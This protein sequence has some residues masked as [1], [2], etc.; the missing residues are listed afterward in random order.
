M[1]EIIIKQISKD[2]GGLR[3]LDKID[4]DVHQGEVFGLIGTNGSGKSTLFNIITGFMAP[5]NGDII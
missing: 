4:I 2:F 1:S 5:T 3:A